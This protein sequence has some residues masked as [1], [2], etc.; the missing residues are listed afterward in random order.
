MMVSGWAIKKATGTTNINGL[1][2]ATK[3]GR[4]SANHDGRKCFVLGCGFL[5][6]I[7]KENNTQQGGIKETFSPF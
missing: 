6:P 2:P 7:G 4:V 1:L 5:S 3:N